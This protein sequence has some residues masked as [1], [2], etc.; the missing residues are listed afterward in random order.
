M[1]RGGNIM[2]IRLQSE[3]T[4][5]RL[6]LANRVVMPAMGVN[7]ASPDGGVTEDIIAFYEARA[8]GGAGLIIS[9]IT[10]IEGGAGISEPCQLAA[11]RPSDIGELQRLVDAV[12]KYETGI[13]IQLQH[14]GREASPAIA[15][16]RPVAPSPVANPLSGGGVP[17][18][19]SLEECGAL[20]QKFAL[21]AQI[22][23]AAGADGV[24]LHGAH[25]Y[26]INEFL[27]PAMNFRTDRYGGSF[28]NRMRFLTEILAGIRKSCGPRFPV[29]VRINAE[30]ALPGGIDLPEACRIAAVL[31]KAG[32]DA[33]NVSCY[34][35]GCIEPGTY[36]EGWKKNMPSAVKKAVSIPVIAVCNI[37]SPAAAEALL[38]E[39]ACDFVGV[40]R[41]H[42]ADPE[43]CAKAFSGREDEIRTCI[44]CLGCFGEIVK[45]KRVRC[46]VN[47][48]TGR[49][50][51][52]ASPARDGKERVVAIVGGGPAGIEAALVLK[53]RGFSPVV[54]DRG[55]RLGGT[56]NTADKGYGKEKITRYTDSLIRQAE[57]AGIET[58]LG[59]DASP[60]TIRELDPC[61]VFV[62]C[63]AEPLVPPIPGINEDLVCTAEDVLLGSE[64][65]QGRVVVVGSGMTGLETAEML[66]MD[67]CS[68]T[69]VEMLDELGA[70]V[71]PTVVQ[72]VMGRIAQHDAVILTGHRLERVTPAGVELTRLSDGEKVAVNADRVVLAMGVVPRKAA[73]DGFKA[74]FPNVHVIG[75]AYRGARILEATRDAHGKAFTFEP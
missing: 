15:G 17:R 23:M 54:F 60:E 71:Y 8:R 22:A 69:M 24:E 4:I 48:V 72:D 27:S 35:Q 32:A 55:E 44:G 52:Y 2:Y 74:A 57:K 40:G 43:W 21:S 3:G 25:G 58:R 13:F 53:E 7:L 14:P 31:E 70:G 46:A 61:G 11:Y 20:A 66:A 75:D 10:R 39:G 5:G 64:K 50:R 51:E 19:L 65:L 33:I 49:E 29:S 26:L 18:E 28:E 9:E 1:L 62:A 12:H 67:G 59:T 68:V 73:A 47:P 42:L 37:K 30:E 63:G 56:L 34:S 6:T 41:G 45:A 38:E 16:E 36:E